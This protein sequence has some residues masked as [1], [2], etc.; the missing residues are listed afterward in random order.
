[1]PM[2]V[3][4]ADDSPTVRRRAAATL[5]EAG[6]D[7]TCVE[8]GEAAWTR[9]DSGEAADVLLCDVLMPR[10][11]GYEL[12]RRAK[13]DPRFKDMP[14]MLLRGTFEPWDQAKAETVGADG[15]ITKPFEPEAL[16]TTLK[17][18]ADELGL[19][20]GAAA[21]ESGATMAIHAFDQTVLSPR[22]AAP[23]S[24]VIEEPADDTVDE[25]DGETGEVSPL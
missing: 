3:L 8:D 7:V 16:V 21:P 17:E 11:D 10:L 20:G 14:V 1:M 22:V 4:V 2:K 18:L 24:P 15:F 25:G 9:L 19:G 12:C 23:P 5:G 13:G 6:Y